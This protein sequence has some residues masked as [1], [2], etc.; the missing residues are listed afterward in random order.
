VRTS[1]IRQRHPQPDVQVQ[2]PGV[3]PAVEVVGG[4]AVLGIGQVVEQDEAQ[5]DACVQESS[6]RYDRLVIRVSGVDGNGCVGRADPG[7]DLDVR[8]EV[9]LHDAGRRLVQR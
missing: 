6:C 2:L 9:D 5:V 1:D 7:I 8:R 4:E 3:R